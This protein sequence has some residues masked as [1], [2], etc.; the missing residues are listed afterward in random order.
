MNYDRLEFLFIEETRSMNISILL[1][2]NFFLLVC[3]NE[4]VFGVIFVVVVGV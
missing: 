1:K 2:K 3:D 4:L